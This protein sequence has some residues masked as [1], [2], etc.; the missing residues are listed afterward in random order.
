MQDTDR[1]LLFT[2]DEQV[3]AVKIGVVE[4][5]IRAV[6]TTDLPDAPENITGV[7]NFRGGIIPVLSLR[8]Q[9][10]LP[11]INTRSGEDFIIVKTSNRTLVLTADAVSQ[12]VAIPSENIIPASR[13]LSKLEYVQG[14]GKSEDG[15]III[16]NLEKLINLQD[17]EQLS[18]TLNKIS[19]D[20]KVK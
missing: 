11:E 12:V 7:I 2:V 15:I 17:E 8:R 4:R 16:L 5:I 1:Y 19:G 18:K 20:E 9:F 10:S 6:E 3:L 14:F 13:V